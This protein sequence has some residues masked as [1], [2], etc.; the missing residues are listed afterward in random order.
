MPRSH[1]RD[2]NGLKYLN[3][4][5]ITNKKIGRRT[6]FASDWRRLL[7]IHWG[8]TQKKYLTKKT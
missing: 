2:P 6:I 1:K 7:R 4:W 5:Q 8:K 3:R